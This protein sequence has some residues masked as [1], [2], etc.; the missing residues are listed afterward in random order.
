MT[1]G[2]I[3][4]SLPDFGGQKNLFSPVFKDK[5]QTLFADHIV[6]HIVMGRIPVVQAVVQGIIED[7]HAFVLFLNRTESTAAADNDE[8]HAHSC[9]SQDT[10]RESF[11]I[12]NFAFFSNERAFT[13]ESG[14]NGRS[15][16]TFF[17]KI[18]PSKPIT[19]HD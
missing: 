9:F 18:T 14:N 7:L 5:P 6:V 17:Y 19:F 3:I 11:G 13:G 4:S 12:I 15:C 2:A 8:R 1:H 16:Q 10:S